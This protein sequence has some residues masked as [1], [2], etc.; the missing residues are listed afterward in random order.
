MGRYLQNLVP[1]RGGNPL[2][3][4][5]TGNGAGVKGRPPYFIVFKWDMMMISI[6]EFRMMA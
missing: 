5:S 1:C 3:P 2:D 6:S 4:V